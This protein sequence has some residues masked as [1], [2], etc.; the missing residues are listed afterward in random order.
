M[1]RILAFLMALLM[2]SLVVCSCDG[3]G[4]DKVT[5]EVGEGADGE[6]V[7]P[8]LDFKGE[9]VVV[10]NLDPWEG[11]HTAFAVAS[12]ETTDT[13]DAAIW[14]SNK[15][16]EEKFNFT[17]VED[18]F[19]QGSWETRWIEHANHLIRNFSSGDDVYDFVYYAVGQ[20]PDLI[21]NGYLLDLSEFEQMKMDQ[22][23][24]DTQLNKDITI[25]GRLYM[26]S[27]SFNLMTYNSMPTLLFN[28]DLL[29]NNQI[30]L[31]YD[32]VREGKW[33]LDAL[34]EL[35]SECVNQGTDPGWWIPAGKG[36]TSNYGTGI[37]RDFPPY[38][39]TAAG[40]KFVTETDGDYEFTLGDSQEFYEVMD[41]ILPFFTHCSNGGIGGGDAS[42]SEYGCR[43]IFPEGRIAFMMT[44]VGDTF[45]VMRDA[46][47]DYGV[48]PLPK[49]R[50]EQ[51]NYITSVEDHMSY[52]CMPSTSKNPEDVAS[53]LDALSYDRYMN[54]VP[55]YY[56]SF[57][58]YKGLR[59]EDSIEMLQIM[60]AGRTV[61]IGM[62]YG[63]CYE[64]VAQ[65]IGWNITSGN[66]SSLI[67]A[68]EGVINDFIDEFIYNSFE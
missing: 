6:Y 59:D 17:L 43:K 56:D 62:A 21:T 20:R 9:N 34:Y 2:L 42:T 16:L 61:D 8:N 3:G 53:L 54:V 26:A 65:Q 48:L 14:E 55:V 33:T 12:D 19:P 58:T 67:A 32:L 63:M 13:L 51:E 39:L 37:H 15:R 41:K 38:F 31:P 50:E 1:K 29:I 35:A 28:K 46:E 24:W 66:A 5:G 44:S 18:R 68:N 23:W 47:V 27:G 49:M 25:N 11:S 57:V 52:L 7:Y 45:A 30:E 60:T 22:P 36:G 4:K 64:L 10:S 40:I